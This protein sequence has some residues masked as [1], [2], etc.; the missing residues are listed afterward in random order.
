MSVDQIKNRVGEWHLSR[1]ALVRNYKLVFNV[2]SKRW[3]G[4]VANLQSTGKFEDVVYGVVYQVSPDQL[5]KLQ[6][7]EGVVP[8]EIR[9][10]L[11]DGNEIS[12]AKAFIWEKTTTEQAPPSAYRKAM[13]VGLA[14]HGYDKLHVDRVFGPAR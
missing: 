5:G 1:R 13:E 6:A 2:Y 9:V 14:D 10:E 12:H 4:N 11:E 3:Q 8:S 7:I